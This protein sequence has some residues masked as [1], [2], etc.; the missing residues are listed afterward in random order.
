MKRQI[1]YA[2][3]DHSPAGMSSSPERRRLDLGFAPQLLGTVCRVI[4]SAG[5]AAVALGVTV[6][7]LLEQCCCAPI[8]SD[9]GLVGK[10]F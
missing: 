6:L 10:F 1:G 4:I 3:P 5:L 7:Q 9:S 8:S 2:R